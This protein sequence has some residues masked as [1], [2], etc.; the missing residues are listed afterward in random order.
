MGRTAQPQ[1]YAD[2]ADM[3]PAR[4]RNY[5]LHTH[6]TC[7]DGLL[8]PAEL[9]ARAAQRGV[10]ALA[11]TDHD[12]VSGLVEA[13]AA[14]DASG[15][16]LIF[17]VE[18]SVTWHE[19]T[20]HVLGLRIDPSNA[21]LIEGLRT[22]RA[23]RTERAARMDKALERVG[24]CGALR[25]A[26]A[27]VTNTDLVSRTH[28]ARY[29][30]QSGRARDMQDVFDRYLGDGKPG[31]VAHE[32]ANLADA[33]RWIESAGGMAV[34]AHPGRYKLGDNER[35]TLLSEFKERGGVGIEVVTGSHAPDHYAFWARQARRHD[36]LAS[37]GSDFHG[38]REGSRDLGRLPALPAECTP[39]WSRFAS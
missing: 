23:G 27:F 17:G 34:L 24:I 10:D 39:I 19:H 3:N 36:F 7:S 11:L 21:I 33:T 6:S 2:I 25:G 20:L 8:R 13:Q 32:W 31:Y 30:V 1:P 37:A 28:F 29:L 12:D 26:H 5:D 22:N 4:P 15:I 35:E 14:A 38:V 18:I 9:V 16:E